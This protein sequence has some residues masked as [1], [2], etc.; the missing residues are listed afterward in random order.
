MVIAPLREKPERTPC[1]GNYYVPPKNRRRGPGRNA[2]QLK[3]FFLSDGEDKPA[4]G[5]K[6]SRG[7]E[8]GKCNAGKIF[9]KLFE[10]TTPK[11]S[12]AA[13]VI[14]L[15]ACRGRFFCR[16][17]FPF[18]LIGRF[19]SPPCTFVF[20]PPAGF[21]S[22]PPCPIRL[23]SQAKFE[24][25]GKVLAAEPD[26]VEKR[27]KKMKKNRCSQTCLSRTGHKNSQ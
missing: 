13:F 23:P 1:L 17:Q 22:S 4:A 16:G 11:F 15:A 20:L 14:H 18:Q 5:R 2:G 19:F 10:L 25:G 6:I 27:R 7:R 26:Y 8:F 24:A 12:F 9:A 21:F 3:V